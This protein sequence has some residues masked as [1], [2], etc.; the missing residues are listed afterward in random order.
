VDSEIQPAETDHGDYRRSARHARGAGAPRAKTLEEHVRERSVHS[1]RHQSV[2]ARKRERTG[3]RDGIVEAR[4]LA[5]EDGLQAPCQRFGADEGEEEKRRV[6]AAAEAGEVRGCDRRRGE[7][8][9]RAPKL[10]HHLEARGRGWSRVRVER[11]REPAV[12]VDDRLARRRKHDGA[13]ERDKR[14]QCPFR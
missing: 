11:D 12:D 8:H 6:R 10:S 7:E 13:E 2:P 1:K 3:G 14:H 9:G 5:L 4:P